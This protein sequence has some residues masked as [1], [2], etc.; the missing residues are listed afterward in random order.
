MGRKLLDV[1][2]ILVKLLLQMNKGQK[3]LNDFNLEKRKSYQNDFN[4]KG[5]VIY[6]TT[7]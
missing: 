6:V 2:E 3:I 7:E 1:L 4:N 5:L